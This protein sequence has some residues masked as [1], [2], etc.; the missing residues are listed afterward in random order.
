VAWPKSTDSNGKTIA[1]S[2][3][4]LKDR[5]RRASSVELVNVERRGRGLTEQEK[6]FTWRRYGQTPIPIIET[7]VLCR[8]RASK[9]WMELSKKEGS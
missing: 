9:V 3:A 6:A 1:Q 7:F 4:I 2:S 5:T 8:G